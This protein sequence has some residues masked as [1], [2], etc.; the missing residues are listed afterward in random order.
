LTIYNNPSEYRPFDTLN[1]AAAAKIFDKFSTMLG[2]SSN[3][4]FLQ[5]QCEFTDISS[6]DS[7]T[8]Q[9]IRNVCT[10]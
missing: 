4:A 8:Q 5:N 9:H 7:A 2:M 10:K 6:L 3:D 1:K